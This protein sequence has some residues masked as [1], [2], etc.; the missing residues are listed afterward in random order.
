M[1]GKGN[2]NNLAQKILNIEQIDGNITP[3]S[4][5]LDSSSCIEKESEIDKDQSEHEECVESE[6]KDKEIENEE[7]DDYQSE[8]EETENDQNKDNQNNLEQFIDANL[9]INSRITCML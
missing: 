3:S 4:S 1:S 2:T 8:D 6:N 9:Y 5:M 7:T